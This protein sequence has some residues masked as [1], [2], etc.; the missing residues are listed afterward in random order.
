M[1]TN[2]LDAWVVYDEEVGCGGTTLDEAE[3]WGPVGYVQG[4]SYIAMNL[5]WH[6]GCEVQTFWL[7][8]GLMHGYG[9]RCM[10]EPPDMSGLQARVFTV[11][12]LLQYVMPSLSSHLAEH[13]Q[14]SLGLI[15]TDWLLTLFASSVALSPLAEL[16]DKFF[17]AGYSVVYRLILAR[18]RCLQQWLMA[19]TD[20]SSLTFLIRSAHV[21]FDR[22]D[23]RLVARLKA[24]SNGAGAVAGAVCASNGGETERHPRRWRHRIKSAFGIG[25]TSGAPAVDA[26]DSNGA[27]AGLCGQS[28]ARPAGVDEADGGAV[29]PESSA[30]PPAGGWTCAHC[31]SSEECESWLA[32]VTELSE[33]EQVPVDLIRHFECIFGGPTL[34]EIQRIA[35]P[36]CERACEEQY[37]AGGAGA[38]AGSG[39]ARTGS[40]N[41]VRD[42]TGCRSEDV[43]ISSL[44]LENASL[45]AAN[46]ELRAG[47]AAAAQMFREASAD[48]SQE[49]AFRSA[50]RLLEGLSAE[51]APM[52]T[53]PAPT[54]P[55]DDSAAAAD[56]APMTTLPA[57]VAPAADSANSV[58]EGACALN[59][60][61]ANESLT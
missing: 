6:A 41:G 15:I 26:S 10:F 21:N 1:L 29:V 32:L 18:L 60:A 45:R 58:D 61:A 3:G 46:A 11:Q 39:M 28:G 8:V 52:T 17:T 13:L 9:L 56:T 50:L 34:P 59:G 54:A 51:T 43:E 5:L 38:G 36:A 49:D 42:T 2:V 16:W 4:M 7:F 57:P 27:S 12:Q 22:I 33:A 53:L 40:S 37:S 47:C 24:P 20:F 30:G 44:R 14:N 55:A 48:G 25:S 31:N 23:G 19:E 35:L